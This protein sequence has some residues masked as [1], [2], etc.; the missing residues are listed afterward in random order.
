MP[1]ERDR[2]RSI[3]GRR[4]G[5]RDLQPGIAHRERHVDPV[6][7][8]ERRGV[9]VDRRRQRRPAATGGLPTDPPVGRADQES[10]DR[11][12]VAVRVQREPG[13]VDV[14]AGRLVP[15]P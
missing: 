9:D 10:V 14:D 4:D 5:R 8:R 11:E 13:E 6:G 15:P 2:H 12:T 1:A 7:E 3:S